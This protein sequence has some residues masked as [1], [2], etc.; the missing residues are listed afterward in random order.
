[1]RQNK[2][3]KVNMAELYLYDN[4]SNFASRLINSVASET[5]FPNPRALDNSNIQRPLYGCSGSNNADDHDDDDDAN[6]NGV[7]ASG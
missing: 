7:A 6:D 2:E 5:H 4:D 3:G 1:M